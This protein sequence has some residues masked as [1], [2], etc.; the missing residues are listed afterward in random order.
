MLKP[1]ELEKLLAAARSGGEVARLSGPHRELLYVL[2]LPL[3][4]HRCDALDRLA[5]YVARPAIA[6]ERLSLAPDGRVPYQ[7]RRPWR[8]GWSARPKQSAMNGRHAMQQSSLLFLRA[9]TFDPL[10]PNAHR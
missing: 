5:R 6:T 1:D 9:G 4:A 7:L 8:D 3:G 2:A 10:P